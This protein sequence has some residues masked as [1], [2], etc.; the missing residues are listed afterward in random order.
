MGLHGAKPAGGGRRAQRDRLAGL[1]RPGPED[2]QPFAIYRLSIELPRNAL[3]AKFSKDHPELAIEIENRMDVAPDQLLLDVRLMGPGAGDWVEELQRYPEVT[4]VDI[5][6][7]GPNVAQYRL[8]ETTPAVHEVMRSQ[9]MLARYPI[10]IREGW[11]RFET[12][13]TASEIRRA[14]A[15]LRRRVGATNVEAVRRASVAL[16]NLGLSPS[17][18]AVFRV[19]RGEGYYDVPRRV[20]LTDLAARLGK[21]KSTVS[22]TL[23]RIEKRL[24]DSALQLSLVP[25]SSV[26]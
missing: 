24:A 19:A 17:Q 4:S 1:R 6:G 2:R 25:L 23:T 10:T 16:G 11:M 5:R 21:S 3:G 18:E 7:V 12:V 9:R 22:E 14:V 13:A 20:S 26:G 15:D 8:A